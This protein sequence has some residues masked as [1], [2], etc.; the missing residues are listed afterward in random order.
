[1]I[2]AGFAGDDDVKLVQPSFV[3][4]PKHQRVMAGAVEGDAGEIFV[5][6]S[7]AF[8]YEVFLYILRRDI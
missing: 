6:R 5:G 4:R 8:K 2:K 3:G 7:T 1:M